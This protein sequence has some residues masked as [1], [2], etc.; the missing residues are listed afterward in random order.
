MNPDPERW[1]PDRDASTILSSAVRRGALP[2]MLVA[3]VAAAAATLGD[4]GQ[5]RGE[6]APQTRPAT[7]P[8][9]VIMSRS[10]LTPPTADPLW[11]VISNW[12]RLRQSSSYPFQDYADFLIAH[13]GWPDEAA[14]RRAA[15][16]QI[17]PANYSPQSVAAFFD[18][19]P[20]LSSAGRARRAEALFALGRTQEA[21]AAAIAAWTSNALSPEDEARLLGRFSAQF[22][23]LD[24]D[25]RMERLLW[26][27]AT[28]AASRQ[29]AWTSAARRPLYEARLAF[30]MRAPDAASRALALGPGADRDAGFIAD[31]AAWLR[32]TGQSVAART[33]LARARSLDALPFDSE[34]FLETLLTTARAAANDDQQ[35]L[36]YDI[37]RQ[38]DDVFAPGTVIRDQPFGAR[39]DYTSLA[40]LAGITALKKLGRP[41][42]AISMFTRY[43]AASQ[44]PQSRTKGLYWAGRAAQAAGDMTTANNYY[45]QA[46]TQIDQ[47][48]GQLAAERLGRAPILP[49][50]SPP[51]PVPAMQRTA[52]QG[53]ELVRAARLLGRMGLWQ[54]QTLFVRQIAQ[55]VRNEADHALAIELATQISRPDLG[56]MVSRMARQNGGRDP[57]RIGFPTL[58]VPPTMQ[59]HWTI[60]HAITRQESQFDRQATSRVGAKGMM[61][62][63]PA[64]AREQAQKLGLSYDQARLAEP[65]YNVMLGSA[66]FDRL[67]NY[68]GGNYVLAVASYNAGPGNVNKFIRNNG[69]PR[70]AGVDVVDWIEAI[71]LSETRGYV[72]R[73]LENAVV[74][75]LMN[76]GRA[77]TPAQNRLSHYLGKGA[78]G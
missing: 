61:Q 28:A 12:S 27:R 8:P 3:S 55:N 29:I 56:V 66:Y 65:S 70:M 71:P 34:K 73:V 31:R 26:D 19:F 35:T 20:P 25:R 30:Q 47:Y 36:A 78:P 16:R 2:L 60:I 40:W 45:A 63:M 54:D 67:L 57:I 69:D 37:A 13:P 74:Y 64:T 15:E 17:D 43:T 59:S 21:R 7:T 77:R 41:A 33:Y 18:R 62:L 44:T 11:S 4:D 72:Q 6:I 24:H 22:S 9:P 1:A 58:S 48:Y 75:D 49:P 53:S 5:I 76:P 52:F 68:F 39:D 50:E 46:A 32:D 51:A 23:P 38:V 14:L 10:P 42:D